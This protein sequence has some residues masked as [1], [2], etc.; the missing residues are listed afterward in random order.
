MPRRFNQNAEAFKKNVGTFRFN[1]H[2]RNLKLF[3]NI[4]PQKVY[5]LLQKS[6]NSQPRKNIYK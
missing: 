3:F 5:K 2:Q 6:I 1:G 4:F